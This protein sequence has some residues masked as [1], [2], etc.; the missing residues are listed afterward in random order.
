MAKNYSFEKGK[1]GIVTGTIMPFGRY[2]DGTNPEGTDWVNYVPAGF[3]RCNGLIYKARDFR[4]LAEILGIGSDCKFA[5]EGFSLEEAN[6][7]LTLGQF[8]LPDLGSKYVKAS[9]ASGIYDNLVILNPN[10]G[11]ETTRVGLEVEM[12]LN[13]GEEIE[14]FFSGEFAVPQTEVPFPATQNFGTTLSG[15]VPATAFQQDNLLPHGHYSNAAVVRSGPFS[16]QVATWPGDL[17]AGY[18]SDQVE[19]QTALGGSATGVSHNH[20]LQRSTV[21]RSTT[22]NISAF[23]LSADQIVTTTRINMDNTFKMDDLQHKYILVEY[24]IKT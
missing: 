4:A 16:A 23:D 20:S 12:S 7:D 22:H 10:T 6:D 1:Y 13:R 11:V 3:L 19:T 8:Q 14:T 5:K 9:N 18:Y 24:L 15:Q 21:S 2:L 17:K